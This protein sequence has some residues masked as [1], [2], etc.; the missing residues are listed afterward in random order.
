MWLESI[1]DK[2][3]IVMCHLISKM[4]QRRL[5]L[6]SLLCTTVISI[7]SSTLLPNLRTYRALKAVGRF[8]APRN[9]LEAI[10]KN[11]LREDHQCGKCE[12]WVI[13]MKEESVLN[14][15]TFYIFLVI[16]I[17]IKLSFIFTSE[18]IVY[19]VVS[20]YNTKTYSTIQNRWAGRHLK[21]KGIVS[22]NSK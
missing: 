18:E 8:A 20:I 7:S 22:W 21:V 15:I 6:V 3:L 13:F 14:A 16:I 2:G 5:L 19:V 1:I 10:L 9:K 4:E 11:R 12:Y 17:V